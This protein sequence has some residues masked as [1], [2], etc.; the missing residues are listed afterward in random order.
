MTGLMGYSMDTTWRWW[1]S[2]WLV[3]TLR[4]CAQSVSAQ[5]R[6]G[7]LLITLS[8]RNICP[9]RWV[10]LLARM[11][12]SRDRCYKVNGLPWQPWGQKAQVWYNEP[13]PIVTVVTTHLAVGG[14]YCPSCHYSLQWKSLL[15]ALLGRGLSS[16]LI[17][18]VTIVIVR[19]TL[20]PEHRGAG[21]LA[22]I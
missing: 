6:K 7:T 17:D 8:V 12:I 11:S 16:L 14:W 19:P 9:K 21:A 1:N 13:K 20:V 2:H 15:L 3:V 22:G 18:P 10:P 4:T 5:K